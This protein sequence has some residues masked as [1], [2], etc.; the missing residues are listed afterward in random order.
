VVKILQI[1]FGSSSWFLST[2]KITFCVTDP[3]KFKILKT[4]VAVRP[5]F[6]GFY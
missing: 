1:Y 5:K 6:S 4:L 2:K 3:S